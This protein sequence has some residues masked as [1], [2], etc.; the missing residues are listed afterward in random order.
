MCFSLILGQLSG[1][2]E[3]LPKGQKQFDGGVV[4][5]K[6]VPPKKYS[7][8]SQFSDPSPACQQIHGV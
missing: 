6:S 7:V 1:I 2:F 5:W 3:L 4:F 8:R